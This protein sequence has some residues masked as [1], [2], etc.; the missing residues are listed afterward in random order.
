M[1]KLFLQYTDSNC[2]HKFVNGTKKG[3]VKFEYS[4]Y[5]FMGNF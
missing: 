1:L 4:S 5:V 2:I 3:T